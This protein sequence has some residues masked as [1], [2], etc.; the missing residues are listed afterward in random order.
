M[1]KIA[2]G[3]AA[4]AILIATPAFAETKS[5]TPAPAASA[6]ASAGA[7]VKDKRYC[8]VEVLTGTRVPTKICKT[9]A[10]WMGE[11]NFDPLA[12]R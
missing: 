12:K 3:F 2:N 6:G 9:R 5:G 1:Y 10:Q 7:V 4:A 8:V 11:D